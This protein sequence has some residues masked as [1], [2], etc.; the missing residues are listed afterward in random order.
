MNTYHSVR[1][2]R[3]TL[4]H[5]ALAVVLGAALFGAAPSASAAPPVSGYT[6]WFDASQIAANNGDAVSTWNDLSANAAN[7]TVPGGNATP[8]YVANAG[9]ETG[10]GA[11]YFAGNGGA[12]NSAALKFTEDTGIRT[13]FS[14]FK[15]CSFLLTDASQYHFHRPSDNNAGDALFAGYASGNITGGSTYVNG[16]L[17]NGTNDA[18]P[19]NV[20]NGFNLVEILTTG[21][22]Q[23]D[24]FNKDRIYHSGNQYQAEVIIYDRLLSE[25]ERVEVEHY[26][27]TKW[28]A[29][30]YAPEAK[31]TSFGPG[32]SVAQPVGGSANIAWTVSSSMPVTSLAPTFTL[33]AG[34]TCTLASGS[35]HDFTGPV[36]YTVTSL[37]SLITNHY[38][39]TVSV[40]ALPV[41][42]DLN[43][44]YDAAAGVTTSGTTVTGWDDQSGNGNH[45]TVGDGSPA[46]ATSQINGHPAVQFR[47]NNLVIDHN[48]T[49]GQ[50]FIVLRSGRY[51]YDGGNPSHWGSDWGG[52]IGQQN[53]SGWMLQPDSEQMWDGNAPNA[54]SVNGTSATKNGNNW[55]FANDVNQYM[56]LKVNPANSGAAFGR[57]GRPN[58]SWGDG[59][60]DVAEVIV[61]T[62]P[63]S[64]DDEDRVGGYLASKYAIA[65]AYPA[66]T[67]VAVI[68]RFG[69]AENPAVV[70]QTAHTID[71]YVPFG[72]DVTSLA[73]PYK[74]V[75]SSTCDKASGSSQNFS[76]PV[77]YTVKS[78][79]NAITTDYVVTVHVLPN[80]PTLINVNYSGGDNG[81]LNG[82]FSFDSVARGSAASVAPVNYA[83]S[84][85]TDAVGNSQASG[86]NLPDSLGNTT[87]V[88]FTTNC[89]NG[90][91]GD[92]NALGG[93]R[94]SHAV[95]ADYTSYQ[96]VLTLNGLESS[97]QYDL[98]I[99]STHNNQNKP[100]DWLV[101]GTVQH[102]ENS[103]GES[104]NWVA[105]KSFVHFS[106]V[107]PL[108]DG[109]IVIK[110][111]GDGEYDGID[112]NA[113]QIQD[114]GVR[115]LNAEALIYDF[116]F[117]SSPGVGVTN[118]NGT[119]ISV[120]MYIGSDVSALIPTFTTS[121]GA[122]VTVNG[123]PLLSG[124]P[125]N[126]SGGPLHFIVKS[127]DSS[128]TTN[129]T[130]TVSLVPQSGHIHLNIT[131]GADTGLYGPAPFSGEGKVWNNVPGAKSGNNLLDEDGIATSVGFNFNNFEG[132][133]WWG[134]PTLT[135]LHGGV[136][137]WSQNDRGEGL[138]VCSGE[139]SGLPAGKSYN[140]YIASLWADRFSHGTFTVNGTSQDLDGDGA[141]QTAWVEGAN[142]VKFLNVPVDANGK[143]VI[144]ATGTQ[145]NGD[146]PLMISGLQLL[147]SGIKSTQCDM[148]AF[149]P[150]AT[151]TGT[152]IS[153]LA[154]Y[155]SDLTSL[156]A[157]FTTSGLASVTVGGVPVVSGTPANFSGPVHYIVTADD[158]VSFKDYTVTVTIAASPIGSVAVWYDAAAG[159]T[160]DGNG[161]LTW[162]DLS[163][164]GHTAT[165]ASGSV[166]LV[167][168]DVNSL[169]AVHLRGGNTYLSC[170]LP[171]A[172]IVKEQYLVVRSPHA[173][174]NGTGCFLGR[175]GGFLDVRGS[176]YDMYGDGSST[177]FW[178][179]HFPVAVSKN[180]TP[181]SNAA[182]PGGNPPRFMLGTITDYMILKIVVDND[183]VANF[184]NFPY[185]Q[186]GKEETL[187]TMD[188]D[189]AEI[190]G[191][192]T[193]LSSAD[194]A[195]VT[196]YLTNK[197]FSVGGYASWATTN[198]GGQTADQDYN[199]DGVAN[200]VAYFMGATGR[201]T[202]PSVVGGKVAWPH[203]A[204]ATGITYKVLTSVNLADWTDDT[205]AAVDAGG[206]LTYTLVPGSPTRFVRLEVQVP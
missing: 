201:V 180:G 120:N 193:Q 36:E 83:G 23:A 196:N 96:P 54:V 32:A 85:W 153:W 34:A 137:W 28:F 41:V 53:D 46:L 166:S 19:T 190:M 143:I 88:G 155:G 27:M 145:K 156:A 98:Y 114:M 165:R 176:S 9:T 78:S 206:F 179:D 37:D 187:G 138:G 45:A 56:V 79:D 24:S 127:E 91:W 70:D 121:T 80:W 108:A 55:H 4:K 158:G 104:T 134:N 66:T 177:G 60:L 94:I 161:V 194:E 112:L 110:A 147:D 186:I 74:L 10:L 29:V 126:F 175:V 105:G 38:F 115:G 106:N 144:K 73:P 2:C 199:N 33:S 22:V 122:T 129:Y 15:G 113:F 75:Y 160:Q 97:H 198:V 171:F 93:A 128:N 170:A 43:A 20:H 151:I 182:G 65:S 168:N 64:E 90:P 150:G 69:P 62:T 157:T 148:L 47:G 50:E 3:K 124:N 6:R 72:T 200:G 89:N 39:V 154:P 11:V 111:R 100:A 191:F 5:P 31:I 185:Y 12:G 99:A 107:I 82:I 44:W 103:T 140:L 51:S 162:S 109:T 167:P 173:N 117:G 30:S 52:P 7:A 35:I 18:I 58:N 172:S 102:L 57:L 63:L 101:G 192:S 86:S 119:D 188:F 152:D 1:N 92:W 125:V 123:T 17:V 204:S 87:T 76:S 136:W 49:P 131:P 184:A 174:W 68:K 189:V 202:N 203:S 40:A 116:T 67:P 163:G 141:S 181:V 84:T 146:Q 205:A 164:N 8:V 16:T 21:T 25:D 130:V 61:Y 142:Y 133:G 195:T 132:T 118:L 139:I 13:V 77:T 95:V 197:Y 14:V 48:I 81:N 178:Q 26:L 135:L 42:T 169:P 159:V 71:W 183:G 149:G 59:Q